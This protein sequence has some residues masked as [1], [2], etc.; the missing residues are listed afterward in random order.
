MARILVIDDE[1]S[2][3]DLL[4]EILAGHGHQVETAA[5]GR[6]AVQLVRKN[7]YDLL[8]LDRNMPHMTGLEAARMIRA[9]TT[10]ANR[11]VKILICT[12]ASFPREVDEAFDAGANDYLLKPINLKTLMRKV[13]SLLVVK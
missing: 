4:K 11:N 8:I 2:I 7:P 9:D 12:S 5:D 1:A 6:E 3:C 10:S 13:E